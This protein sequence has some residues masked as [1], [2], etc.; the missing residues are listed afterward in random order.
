MGGLSSTLCMCRC[1]ARD[2]SDNVIEVTLITRS[3]K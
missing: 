3:W 1:A 2:G